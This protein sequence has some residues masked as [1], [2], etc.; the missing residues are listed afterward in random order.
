[1]SRVLTRGRGS[2]TSYF[3]PTS[4]FAVCSFP[5]CFLIF[6]LCFVNQQALLFSN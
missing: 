2:L 4:P 5:I 3:Y 6:L 1:M